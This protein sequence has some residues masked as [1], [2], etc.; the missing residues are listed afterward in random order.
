MGTKKQE[1]GRWGEQV[2][3]DY[4]SQKGYEIIGRNIQTPHGEID[5]LASL[6]QTL[7]FIEVKTRTNTLYGD[8]ENSITSRKLIHM[9]ESAGYYIQNT[10]YTGTWQCDVIAILKL[11]TKPHEI[12]HFENVIS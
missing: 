2:A 3:S 6:E 7:I 5:I 9:E 11:A 10:E 8:P 12:V 1:L 4:L